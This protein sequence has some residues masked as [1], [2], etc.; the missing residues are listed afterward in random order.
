MQRE[1]SND[2]KTTLTLSETEYLTPESEVEIED[3]KTKTKHM[4]QR[5][6]IGGVILTSK[7]RRIVCN[8]TILSRLELCFEELLP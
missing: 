2:I 1:A 4:E 3:Q 5:G 8:N 7:D 6:D